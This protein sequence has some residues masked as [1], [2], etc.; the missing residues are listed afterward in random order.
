MLNPVKIIFNT[1][2]EMLIIT[3]WDQMT[4]DNQKM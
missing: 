3:I 1:K 2:E 4:K